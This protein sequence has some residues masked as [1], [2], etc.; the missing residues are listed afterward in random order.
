MPKFQPALYANLN[1]WKQT[2]KNQD[3]ISIFVIAWRARWQA[4]Q[5]RSLTKNHSRTPPRAPNRHLSRCSSG[6]VCASI[7]HNSQETEAE[8]LNCLSADEQI[9]NPL[10][11]LPVQWSIVPAIKR[12]ETL[13]HVKTWMNLKHIMAGKRSQTQK[14]T[15]GRI[16][17]MGLSPGGRRG[18]GAAPNEPGFSL[19]GESWQEMDGVCCLHSAMQVLNATG[20]LIWKWTFWLL[21]VT[22]KKKKPH[23]LVWVILVLSVNFFSL[24]AQGILLLF[25][26]NVLQWNR[27]LRQGSQV[28][29]C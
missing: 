14:V 17:F 28:R 1:T 2:L 18:G 8:Q 15:Y 7:I 12:N 3:W 11:G 29:E 5:P 19:D 26:G 16:L 27:K 21:S 13:K 22:Q 6:R 24:T 23:L 20:R 25:S 9:N 4:C 10:F